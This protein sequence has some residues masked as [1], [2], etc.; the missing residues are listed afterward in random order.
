MAFSYEDRIAV[1]DLI[2]LHGHLVDSG[3]LDRMPE[4][5]T[6]DGTYD[7]TDFGVGSLEGLAALREAAPAMGESNPVGHHVTN[8][9]LTELADGRVRAR[10]KGIGT[11]ADGTSGSVT[12]DDVVTR[13]D[14]G[15]RI[16]HRKIRAHRATLG[17]G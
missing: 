1:T 14:Q 8:I 16:S 17:A 6:P 13:G 3:E 4:V 10:S 7:V 11:N 12:Y 5:F 2:C 9:V 15:W